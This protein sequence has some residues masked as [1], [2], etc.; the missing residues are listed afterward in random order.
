[1]GDLWISASPRR[2]GKKWRAWANLQ[3]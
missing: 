3:A 2:F 1:M